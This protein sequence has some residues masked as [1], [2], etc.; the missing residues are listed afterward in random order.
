MQ[1]TITD[2]VGTKVVD[3]Q[4]MSNDGV[5]LFHKD[6]TPGGTAELGLY[7]VRYVAT[8]GAR[9]TIEDADFVVEE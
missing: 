5:G 7:L 2:P 3:D 4:A 8:D 6:Y 9:V 1:I